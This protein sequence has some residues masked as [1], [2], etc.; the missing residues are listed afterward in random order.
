[1]GNTSIKTTWKVENSTVL[2]SHDTSWGSKVVTVETNGVTTEV[3][4]LA[5]QI[6]DNGKYASLY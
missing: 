6:F 1:M 3:F 5:R 2:L 4:H